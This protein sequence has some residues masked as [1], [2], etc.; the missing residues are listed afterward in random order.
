MAATMTE[1]PPAEPV[2]PLRE[3]NYQHSTDLPALLSH[4]G[5]S[6]LVST[7]Q[8]GKLAV[9]HAAQD[10]LALKFL[11]FDQPM[12]MAVGPRRHAARCLVVSRSHLGARRGTFQEDE[13]QPAGVP[14]EHRTRCTPGPSREESC[15]WHASETVAIC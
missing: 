3:V 15:L 7:Y 12:G 2:A 11:N 13:K 4:L 14:D 6:L 1:A 8:A 5:V 9:I 10:R